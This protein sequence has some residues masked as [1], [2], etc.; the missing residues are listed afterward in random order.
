[1]TQALPGQLLIA[2]DA[3][4]YQSLLGEPQTKPCV[5]LFRP[6][7]LPEREAS[8]AGVTGELLPVNSCLALAAGGVKTTA[9]C[10]Q[11]SSASKPT[12]DA[13]VNV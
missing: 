8:I 11:R 1:M 6:R 13:R 10:A 3:T 7:W 2:R 5:L 9:S 4:S 12:H